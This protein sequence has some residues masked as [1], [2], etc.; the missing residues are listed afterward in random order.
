MAAALFGSLIMNPPCGDGNER[1]A[2]FATGVFLRLHVYKLQVDT[3]EAHRSL[4]GLL[5]NQ[6][7]TFDELFPWILEHAVEA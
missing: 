6:P 3:R 5:E 4:T 1:V 7:C 2:F